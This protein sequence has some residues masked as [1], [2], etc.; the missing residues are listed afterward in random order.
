MIEV[1]GLAKSFG[2]LRVLNGI[3]LRIERGEFVVV[4]GPS[5]AGKS[6]LLRCLSGLV[7]PTSGSIA[8]E[9]VATE[10]RSLPAVRKR[11]GFIFQG[12]NIHGNLTVLENVLVGRLAEK[13]SWGITF[14]SADRRIALEA[15]ERV[16][17]ADMAGARSS[18]LSGGQR[19][20]VGIARALA[21]APT[22]LLAD[23]P[24]SSLDPVSGG[25]ILNL[26]R[27]INRV[28][29]T[30]VLCNLHDVRQATRIADRII[31]LRAGAIVFDGPPD[32]LTT[33]DL[34]RV[35]GEFLPSPDSAEVST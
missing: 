14:S 21:H 22:V 23:E 26:L 24:V 4:L 15:L 30:T 16:G 19:Q 18:T 28:Q 2:P 27:E 32:Q 1:G 20:R 9:G 8:I 31:G 12:V 6:T 5:G 17:L 10:R 13:P 35:Y 29:G 3:S 11:V 25:E 7:R 34:T 33:E